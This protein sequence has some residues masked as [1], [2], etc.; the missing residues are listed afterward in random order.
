MTRIPEDDRNILELAIYLPMVLTIL[1]RDMQVVTSSPFKLK[2]PYLELI[3]E[4][5]KT[6]QAEL[7]RVRRYM[8]NNKMKVEKIQTDDAFTMYMFLYKGY[9]E[10]HNYF[11]PRLRN[12]VE[13]LLRHYLFQRFL[14]PGKDSTK[15][16]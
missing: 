13:E 3:E 16:A 9:E 5:M 8:R 1:N 15:E 14:S 4:T 10:H 7:A 6:I 11:N 12:R 2:R